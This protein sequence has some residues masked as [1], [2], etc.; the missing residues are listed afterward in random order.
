[1]PNA[2]NCEKRLIKLLNNLNWN[3]LVILQQTY[4]KEFTFKNFKSHIVF[5]SGAIKNDMFNQKL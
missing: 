1:M 5:D 2:E 3:K 4:E